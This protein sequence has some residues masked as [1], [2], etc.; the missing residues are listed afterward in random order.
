MAPFPINSVRVNLC[1]IPFLPLH[2]K[3]AI[4]SS[5]S[6][7]CEVVFD[8][9]PIDFTISLQI[10]SDNE[11]KCSIKGGEMDTLWLALHWGSP[12]GLAFFFVGLGGMIY[13]LSKADEVSKRTKAFVKEKGLDWKKKE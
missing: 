13:L 9:V 5:K 7:C 4:P 6:A 1:K 3:T 2:F 12:I 8:G 11:N 10:Q